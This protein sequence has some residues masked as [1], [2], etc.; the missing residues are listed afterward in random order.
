MRNSS[1]A[2]GR[3]TWRAAMVFAQA[4]QGLRDA[5]RTVSFGPCC[6]FGRYASQAPGQAAS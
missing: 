4:S 3:L 1:Q 5:M 2:G 6:H